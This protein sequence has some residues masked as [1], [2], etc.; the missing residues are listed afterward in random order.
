[1]ARTWL[2]TLRGS[3]TSSAPR[4][5][6]ACEP[7]SDHP[8]QAARDRGSDHRRRRF[9]GDAEPDFYAPGR[10]LCESEPA[11]LFDQPGLRDPADLVRPP[12][13]VQPEHVPERESERDHLDAIA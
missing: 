4:S 2:E 6:T 7:P 5:S 12:P 3:K 9:V 11:L 1:M 10:D 13:T 8:L